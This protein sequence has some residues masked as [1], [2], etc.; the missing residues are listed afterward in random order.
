M[1]F[2]FLCAG[3]FVVAASAAAG[4]VGDQASQP[5]NDSGTAPDSSKADTS[6][7][8]TSSGADAADANTAMCD[9]TKAFG[10]ATLVLGIATTASDGGKVDVGEA[11][12]TS[13]E[14]QIIFATN[15]LT[16]SADF[17]LFIAKRTDRN[18]PFLAPVPLTTLNDTN[19]QR[20]V[21]LS[22]DGLTLYYHQSVA[23]NY[24]IYRTTRG[25]VSDTAFPAAQALSAVNTPG[26]DVSPNITVDGTALYF[27]RESPNHIYRALASNAFATPSVITELDSMFGPAAPVPT[28]D[29]LGLYYTKVT[30]GGTE[31]WFAKRT[32]TNAPYTQFAAVSELN[33]KGERPTWVSR[34]G[35]RLY[36][37]STRNGGSA[38]YQ[39]FFADKP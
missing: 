32:A 7:A 19:D 39:L 3:S 33:V 31:L 22:G 5:M 20:G 9:L 23:G 38:A 25:N 21:S 13:D 1:R 15:H 17:D 30:S 11:A 14:L 29:D 28:A 24:G 37:D 26:V 27:A 34:N 10:A 18:A 16:G 6:V 36:F 35:C 2:Y 4:C 8:D 12:L